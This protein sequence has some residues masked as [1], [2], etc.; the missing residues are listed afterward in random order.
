MLL[1][2]TLKKNASM[3]PDPAIAIRFKQK[4]NKVRNMVQFGIGTYV[5]DF[6]LKEMVA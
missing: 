2:V 3:F 6:M 4:I 5:K 1:T